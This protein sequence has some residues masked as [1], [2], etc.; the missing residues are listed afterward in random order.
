MTTGCGHRECSRPAVSWRWPGRTL[1]ATG[2]PHV[3][4][5]AA[6]QLRDPDATAAS[7]GL[8]RYAP[9]REDVPRGAVSVQSLRGTPGTL[10]A[11]RD[12]HA[13]LGAGQE[14]AAC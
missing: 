8:S 2:L 9:V 3:D 13:V 12:V 14:K 7:A 10:L 1:R 6:P 11:E 4:H 5:G